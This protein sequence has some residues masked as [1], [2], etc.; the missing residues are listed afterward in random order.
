[1][2]NPISGM[3]RSLNAMTKI[4]E[5]AQAFCEERKIDESVLL[6]ARLYPDMF[7]L[8]RNVQTACDNAKGAAARLSETELPEHEDNETSFAE[9]YARIQKTLDFMQSIP[10]SAFE[11]YETREITRKFGPD[12]V[13]FT[14]TSY[15]SIFA[16]P[17]FYFHLTTA[18]GILRHNGV[19]IG[20]R[21][22]LGAN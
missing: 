8:T 16:N 13:T 6:N 17:N 4:L 3:T 1:M 21:D 18:Y 14:G 5:K 7:N 11:G 2:E 19:A 22:F 9:L 20:K 12:E 15:M 10:E